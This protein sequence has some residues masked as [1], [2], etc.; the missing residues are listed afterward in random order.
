MAFE[1]GCPVLG[2]F[3]RAGLLVRFSTS[4]LP[5]AIVDE[6]TTIKCRGKE[7]A[8]R[9]RGLEAFEKIEKVPLELDRLGFFQGRWHLQPRF[10]Q[11]LDQ[12]VFHGFRGGISC[13]G[14]FADEEEFGPFE[15]FLFAE[16]KRLGAAERYQAL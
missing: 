6:G 2:A 4:K 14:E 15:H 16:L 9:H 8:S 7:K 1:L 5:Y 10:R 11:R 12:C 3:S 13:G